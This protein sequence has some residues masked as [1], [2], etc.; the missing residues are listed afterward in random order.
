MTVILDELTPVEFFKYGGVVKIEVNDDFADEC[1]VKKKQTIFDYIK[2]IRFFNGLYLTYIKSHKEL[3]NAEKREDV[4]AAIKNN[5]SLT[6]TIGSFIYVLDFNYDNTHSFTNAKFYYSCEKIQEP[7]ISSR[8]AYGIKNVCFSLMNETDE[9]WDEYTQQR[10]ERGFDDSEIWNLD[11]TL[12]AFLLPRLKRFREAT[13]A[14]PSELNSIDEWYS[15]LDQII[16]GVE[17]YV[18]D[19][20]DDKKSE[21]KKERALELIKEWFSALWW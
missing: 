5:V 8:D 14:Y 13:C 3:A 19:E 21:N 7:N 4:Y 17:L 15:I 18:N 12:A 10:L 6:A 20:T 9:K 2:Y 11:H 1:C 16:E